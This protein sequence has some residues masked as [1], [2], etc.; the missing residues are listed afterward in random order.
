MIICISGTPGTGKSVIAKKLGKKLRYGILEISKFVK[1]NKIGKYNKKLKTIDV[2]VD[3][4]NDKLIKIIKK[5][6]NLIIDGHLS[7]YLPRKY[8]DLCIIVRCNLKVLEK[9]LDKR[10]YNKQKIK[11]NLEAE[12]FDTSLDEAYRNKHNIIVIENSGKFDVKPVLR[13]IQKR[14]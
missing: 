13:L 5:N 7:H 9:R 8:V 11:D 10:G 14:L 6:K 4:L 2:D 12:I 3:K 1:N